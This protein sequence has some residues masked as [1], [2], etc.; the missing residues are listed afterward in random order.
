MNQVVVFTPSGAR[1]LTNPD[2]TQ[3]DKATNVLLNPEFPAGVSPDRWF[4]DGDKIG[5][6]EVSLSAIETPNHSIVHVT[7][8]SELSV[9]KVIA[10]AISAAVLV[11][12]VA[13]GI[14]LLQ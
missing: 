8:K 12:A 5:V 4:R 1:I 9:G 10:I 2:L 11:D 13:L 7:N 14:Y 3:F 6:S